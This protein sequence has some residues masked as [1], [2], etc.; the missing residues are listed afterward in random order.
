[1]CLL[2]RVG[3][4]KR[5]VAAFRLQVTTAPGSLVSQTACGLP[6]ALLSNLASGSNFEAS[7]F[8]EI[9]TVCRTSGIFQ[10]P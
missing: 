7:Q 2:A 1:M 8:V 5:T 10:L 9:R 4:Q 6:M 3:E